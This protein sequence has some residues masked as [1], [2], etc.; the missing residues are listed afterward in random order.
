MVDSLAALYRSL[1][2][3]SIASRARATAWVVSAAHPCDGGK[4]PPAA[5]LQSARTAR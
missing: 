5:G 3:S 1:L 2:M 4:I